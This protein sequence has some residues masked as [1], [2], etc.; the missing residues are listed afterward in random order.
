[1]A[2]QKAAFEEKLKQQETG[3]QMVIAANA[4]ISAEIKELQKGNAALRKH[5]KQI[6]ESNRVM[7]TELHTLEAHLGVAKDFTA[8]S[9]KETDDSKNSLLQVLKGGNH[10]RRHKAFVEMASKSRRDADDEDDEDEDDN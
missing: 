3:N 6:Q 1:M 9:L 2:K 4:N 5:A 10:H 7:R 8:S